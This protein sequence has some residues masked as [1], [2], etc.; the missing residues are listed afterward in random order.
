[1]L[2]LT[3]NIFVL[4]EETILCAEALARSGISYIYNPGPNPINQVGAILIGMHDMFIITLQRNHRSLPHHAP[5]TSTVIAAEQM[6]IDRL[7]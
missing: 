4:H 1:M 6:I 5:T 3:V 2:Y 7:L